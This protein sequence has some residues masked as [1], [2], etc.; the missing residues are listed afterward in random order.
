MRMLAKARWL[1]K[2]AMIRAKIVIKNVKT[3]QRLQ[4]MHHHH[5]NHQILRVQA[6]KDLKKDEKCPPSDVCDLRTPP[7]PEWLASVQ[8]S[9]SA[10]GQGVLPPHGRESWENSSVREP[11]KRPRQCRHCHFPGG[12]CPRPRREASQTRAEELTVARRHAVAWDCARRGLSRRASGRSWWPAQ[13]GDSPH[14]LLSRSS[15]SQHLLFRLCSA[16][17]EVPL[18]G[19]VSEGR[20]RICNYIMS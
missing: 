14:C 13:S 4:R 19:S 8:Q 2:R 15:H 6:T 16:A 20:G 3:L 7:T 10:R 11:Q 17:A 1:D 12:Q 5:Q 18:R 9:A